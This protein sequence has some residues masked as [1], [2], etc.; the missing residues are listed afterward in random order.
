MAAV[1]LLLTHRKEKEELKRQR[2]GERETKKDKEEKEVR[3]RMGEKWRE[4]EI[5]TKR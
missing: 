3:E 1:Y 5:K 2:K 4:K